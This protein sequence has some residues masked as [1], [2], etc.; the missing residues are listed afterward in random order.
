MR[1]KIKELLERSINVLELTKKEM[2]K[3]SEER[4]KINY[5]MTHYKEDIKIEDW[6]FCLNILENKI[7][8]NN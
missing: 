5:F 8:E 7:K 3:Y 1:I 6:E 2:D 4:Q